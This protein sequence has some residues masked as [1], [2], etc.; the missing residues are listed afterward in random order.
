LYEKLTPPRVITSDGEIIAGQYKREHLPA[1]AM[2]GL[3]VSAGTIE[4]RARVIFNM[5][6]ADLENGDY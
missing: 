6:E 4:G 3:P 2:V 5:E 1:E